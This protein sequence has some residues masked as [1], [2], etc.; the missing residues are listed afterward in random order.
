MGII[1]CREGGV[2][3]AGLFHGRKWPTSE[4]L[5]KHFPSLAMRKAWKEVNKPLFLPYKPFS[6]PFAEMEKLR[7]LR[8]LGG[9]KNVQKGPPNAHENSLENKIN[10]VGDRSV[11]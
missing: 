4:S 6:S 11:F 8:V 2:K 10:A 5:N 9:E 3:R 7:E 1:A